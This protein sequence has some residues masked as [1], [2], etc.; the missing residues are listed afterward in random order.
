MKKS[1]SVW[2][3]AVAAFLQSPRSAPAA[4]LPAALYEF[5]LNDI[6]GKPQ[7]LS[8]YKGKV[9]LIVNVAS[10][11]GF[12]PQYTGLEALYQKHKDRGLVVLGFPANNFLWQEPGT[13]AEIKTFCSTKYNVTFPLFSKIS[14]KG[15][16]QHPLYRWLTEGRGNPATS[17]D[18]TWNF[19]K[20]LVGRDGGVRAR[21]GSRDTPESEALARA[22]EAALAE[23]P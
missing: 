7:P 23:K 11:C 1:L 13:D 4:E 5:T 14:V 3:A 20:F 21:F 22:V 16:D 12:T 2:I 6:N 19:N 18:V 10:R 9:L 17:G 8:A 15:S